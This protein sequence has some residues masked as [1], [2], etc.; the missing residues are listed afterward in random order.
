[1]SRARVTPARVVA[2][3]VVAVFLVRAI[4]GLVGGWADSQGRRLAAA[5]RLA[6]ALPLL[7]RGA[8]GEDR[9]ATRWLSGEARLGL[10][11][12]ALYEPETEEGLD[13]LLAR[14]FTDHTEAI[15]LSPA[16]GWYW[17][18]LADV[19]HQH[20][21]RQRSPDGLPLE[22]L[23]QNRWTFVGRPGRVAIGL[24]RMAIDREPT[25]YLF[26]DQLAFALLDYRLIDAAV[27]VVGESAR[28]QPDFG[29]HEYRRLS[30]IPEVVIDA[31]ADASREALG[32]VPLMRQ[33]GHLLSLGKLELRRGR[34]GQAE[35]DLRA[36]LELPGTSLNHADARYRLGLA[37]A[38]QSRHEEAVEVLREAEVE[39]IFEPMALAA[40]ASIAEQR[41]ELDQ[42]LALLRRARRLAPMELGY[43]MAYARLA[44][45]VDRPDWAEE[46]L[47]WAVTA[48]PDDPRPLRALAR[49]LRELGKRHE[50]SEVERRLLRIGGGGEAGID[51]GS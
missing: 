48:H 31:F 50:A 1:M 25:Q 17:A 21:R 42:A 43:A 2:V 40:R 19:Y 34:A 6:D 46:A 11:Q 5:G 4:N 12:V 16:S 27:E 8:I 23:D 37:L 49:L 38:A 10:Y 15:S 35:Q 32:R 29:R 36:A 39:P 51:S 30:P 14:A 28:V 47:D 18:S 20:E 9:A 41:G 24:L 22:I 45:A 26:H 7:D 33:F 3:L 44:I 13:E